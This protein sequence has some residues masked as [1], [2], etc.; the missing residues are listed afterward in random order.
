MFGLGHKLTLALSSR[1][2]RFA[3]E[4]GQPVT[5]LRVAVFTEKTRISMTKATTCHG[6]E[7]SPSLSP[8][9]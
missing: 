6:R 9:P 4:Y 7:I 3:T 8:Y 1:H 5:R 2:T